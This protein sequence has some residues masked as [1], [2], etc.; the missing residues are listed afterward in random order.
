MPVE[1]ILSRQVETCRPEDT[2]A[3]VAEKMSEHGIDSLPVI[4]DDG[5]VTSS[6]TDLDIGIAASIEG[7]KL[8]DLTVREAMSRDLAMGAEIVTP[9]SAPPPSAPPRAER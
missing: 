1:G 5:R 2:L 3:Q 4:A 9:W 7:R 8:I 6:I